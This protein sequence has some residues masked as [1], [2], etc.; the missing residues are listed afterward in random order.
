MSKSLAQVMREALEKYGKIGTRELASKPEFAGWASS[1]IR[2]TRN[3]VLRESSK[4]EWVRNNPEK[5]MCAKI[6][7]RCKRFNIYFDIK[8]EDLMIPENCPVLGIPLDSSSSDN[9]PSVDRF[10]PSKGYTP[11]NV[12]VISNRANS[13]KNN[14]T[15]EEIEQL[16]NWVK[17]QESRRK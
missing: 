8:P 6:R 11:D 16:Y 9:V 3:N 17:D 2:E 4:A 1:K 5:R 10:D 7:S 14:A 12:N 13:L 15:V